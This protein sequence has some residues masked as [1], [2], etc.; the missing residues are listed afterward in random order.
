MTLKEIRHLVLAAA[1]LFFFFMLNPSPLSELTPLKSGHKVLNLYILQRQLNELGFLDTVPSGYYCAA[2]RDAV[3]K[4]Q[5]EHKLKPDGIMTS[6]T[7]TII[8]NLV[9]QIDNQQK[10]EVL[11][12]YVGDEPGI[13]SSYSTVKAQKNIV[14]SISPFWYRLDRNDPGQL[15]TGSDVTEQ[16]MY[17]TLD[18]CRQNDISNYALIHNI[19]YGHNSVGKDLA[20]TLF[21]NPVK[22][23][24]QV[25]NIYNLLQ[26]KGF[27]GVCIDIENIYPGD[28]DHYVQFLADLS[29]RLKPAGY[30]II[31]CV[32]AK[33]SNVPGGGWGDNFDYAKV[34]RYADQVVIMTYDE[35]NA[36]S[37]NGPIASVDWVEK[38]I[39]Y[40]LTQIPAEKIIL[41]IP[42]YGFDWNLVQKTSRYLSYQLAMQT[43]R[44]YKSDIK[45]DNRGQVP[46]FNY[47]DAQ[48]S[49][50]S[51][52]FEN[53]DSTAAKLEL[54]NRY[55]LR[56][57]ALWRLGMEDPDIWR[58]IPD[59][60]TAG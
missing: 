34:G 39:Q 11:G 10:K 37:S 2:T 47:H 17:R 14:T 43:S 16:D 50:H 19:L 49:K 59:F 52:Y 15:E 22:R 60:L 8:F 7:A 13:P 12:F 18:F 55:G 33:T 1:L 25:N 48:G 45:W 27:D 41:G 6:Q 57:I 35:H 58:L 46:Y 36:F 32:P 56:G 4:L 53:A 40:A 21:T 26:E 29:S 30:P 24:Q 38:T 9:S 31:V 42:G 20:H 5:S 54:V 51:V 44:K 28:R 23:K 3:Q